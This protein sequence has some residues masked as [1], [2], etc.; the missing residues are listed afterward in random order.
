MVYGPIQVPFLC[1]DTAECEREKTNKM[2]CKAAAETLASVVSAT[3][4]VSVAAAEYKCEWDTALPPRKLLFAPGCSG[5][6]KV[7]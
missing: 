4:T 5:S 7:C 2:I 1:Y 3:T 6:G